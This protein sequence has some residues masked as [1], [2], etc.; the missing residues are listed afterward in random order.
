MD[1]DEMEQDMHWR[2]SGVPPLLVAAKARLRRQYAKHE[3]QIDTSCCLLT[4]T[5]LNP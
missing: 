2:V 5:N 3:Y 1:K 4:T